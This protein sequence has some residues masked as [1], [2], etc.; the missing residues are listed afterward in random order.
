[1]TLLAE[2]D[3]AVSNFSGNRSILSGSLL[4][5]EIYSEAGTLIVDLVLK[6]LYSQEH[7]SFKLRF[8]NVK[9][10]SFYHSSDHIFYNISN[11]KFFRIDEFF[12]LS[13]DPED[14]KASRSTNDSD[15][16]LSKT[17]QAYSISLSE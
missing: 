10:Y 15:F 9:E 5:V 7:P 11:Y 3:S 12:Y 16:I 13:L 4:K 2:N 14:E 17:V 8:L 1:M 6:L